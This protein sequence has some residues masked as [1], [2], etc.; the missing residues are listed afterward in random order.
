[1][2]SSVS[3]S[4]S[5]SALFDSTQH[6][7][8]LLFVFIKMES[9]LTQSTVLDFCSVTNEWINYMD[10]SVA[11]KDLEDAKFIV[12]CEK[13]AG[14]ETLYHITNEGRLCLSHF[15]TK[16]PSSIRSDITKQVKL[17]RMTF[18]RK[19][20]YFADYSKNDDGSYSVTLRITEPEQP[21]VE[22]IMNVPS[23]SVAS[24]IYDKW[25]EKAAGVYQALYD[26]LIE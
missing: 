3:A 16:L 24:Q 4:K 25:E 13:H 9:P 20:E 6:K 15:F 10:C 26:L 19:Q 7:L 2:N 1:M 21:V 18:K 8:L 11:L 14:C 5:I 17:Q 23:R 12:P 22:I